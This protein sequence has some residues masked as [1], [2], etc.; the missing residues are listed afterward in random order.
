MSRDTVE[1]A[2]QAGELFSVRD[3]SALCE[4]MDPDVEW[5]TLMG[6]QVEAVVYRGH[7][8]VRKYF[9]VSAD[10]WEYLRLEADQVIER[11]DQVVILGRAVG[12]GRASGV[13]VELPVAI[14]DR[15]RDGKI[16]FSKTWTDQDAALRDA[17]L[18]SAR[19]LGPP[20]A[21][22]PRVPA[23]RD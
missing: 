7:A 17:G 20:E 9:A 16:V 23:P 8:G 12:K 18:E 15:F 10:A 3:V 5:V 4:L 14:Q 22:Q 13:E 21:P 19:A 6:S 1:L 11:G 2:L